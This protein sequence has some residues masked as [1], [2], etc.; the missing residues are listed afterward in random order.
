MLF[1][2]LLD[3]EIFQFVR[4]L[5]TA[6]PSQTFIN[7]ISSKGSALCQSA[8]AGHIEVVSYLLKQ[9][10]I[11]HWAVDDRYE[12]VFNSGRANSKFSAVTTVG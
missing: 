1:T 3:V 2:L 11:D 5:V 6:D 9:P 7:S 12:T 10:K 4:M 8:A